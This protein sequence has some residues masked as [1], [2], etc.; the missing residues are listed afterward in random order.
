MS[1][2][3]L[4]GSGRRH[5]ALGCPRAAGFHPP[6]VPHPL[7]ALSDGCRCR[8]RREGREKRASQLPWRR[9]ATQS[10]TFGDSREV[11][12]R[13]GTLDRVG[14]CDTGVSGLRPEHPACG[15][16]LGN[17]PLRR[18]HG[19]VS[20]G[21]ELLTPGAQPVAQAWEWSVP[22]GRCPSL[23]RGGWRLL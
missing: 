8:L 21:G 17:P 6:P 10:S 4:E 18:F 13:G 5:S 1:G 23:G 22:R 7:R 20:L 11:V 9:L 16:L 2:A 14:V 12:S 19:S 3:R 15:S